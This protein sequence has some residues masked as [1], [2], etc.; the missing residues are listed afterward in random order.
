MSA[1]EVENANGEQE[2]K[3]VDRLNRI[4]G[5]IRGISRMITSDRSCVD[6]VTQLLAARAALDRVTEQLIT[7]HVDDCLSSLPPDEARA[8]VGKAVRM[9]A[10]IEPGSST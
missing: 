9:L 2:R 6:V 3:L 1:S 10:R 8:A 7:S 5:Q 4:E